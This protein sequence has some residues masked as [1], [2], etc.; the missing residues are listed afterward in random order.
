MR[1]PQPEREPAARTRAPSTTTAAPTTANP[2][3]SAMRASRASRAAARLARAP[4][5]TAAFRSRAAAVLAARAA[6]E[7]WAAHSD[8]AVSEVGA[9]AAPLALAVAACCQPFRDAERRRAVFRPVAVLAVHSA[10]LQGVAEERRAFRAAASALLPWRRVEAV[11]RA[12]AEVAAQAV[13]T[14]E[15]PASEFAD[16]DPLTRG[17]ALERQASLE[18]SPQ[19]IASS[20]RLAERHDAWGYVGS[21]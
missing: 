10:D 1:R 4:R 16:R 8:S 6:R 18:R 17:R 5:A 19:A 11:A 12:A 9:G 20:H 14:A 15:P 13:R 7:E 2:A 21:R 3:C